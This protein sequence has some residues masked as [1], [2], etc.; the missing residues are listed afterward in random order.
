MSCSCG[1]NPC[2]CSPQPPLCCN[3]TTESVEY[4][5]ENQNLSGVGVFNNVT[6]Y[7]VGFRGIVSESVAL[8]VALDAPNNVIVLDFDDSQLIAAIP[9]A[10][11]T[12]RGILETATDAE[13][14]AKALNNKI[15][16]P[17][18]F[19]AMGS[20]TSFAGLVELATN[21]ETI[22]G[23]S[24]TLATTPAGVAAATS[25]YRTV[26]FADAVTRAA[27][28]PSFAGQFAVQLDTDQGY[29]SYGTGAGQWYGLFTLDTTSFI[30]GATV[31]NI[32]G[33]TLLFTGGSFN[34]D[35][36][37][38][39]TWSGSTS[40]DN[41]VWTFTNFATIDYASSTILKI[42]G[43]SIPASSV[44]LTGATA[45]E[46]SSTLISNFLSTANSSGGWTNFTNSLVR[47]TCDCNT[48]TLPELAQIVDTLIQTLGTSVQIPIP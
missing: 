36:T 10:T 6:N 41:A 27:T 29:I 1:C 37:T 24:T 5:F 12:Q 28:I 26:T 3:P 30:S 22:T 35:G 8:T 43:V 14:I 21:A 11:T 39:N 7:L 38:T 48:V 9:D 16:T 33:S 20:T 2:S 13:A 4:T 31:L 44:L 32:N 25:L 40:I 42:A 17:S 23:T 18:N 34:I 19:A 47:K 15:V 46:P 45:G